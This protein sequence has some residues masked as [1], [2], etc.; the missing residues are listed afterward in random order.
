MKKIYD[1]FVVVCQVGTAEKCT[2]RVALDAEKN[3]N[4][5]VDVLTKEA[6]GQ[7]E[8]H[9]C[10]IEITTNENYMDLK[11]KLEEKEIK[12]DVVQHIVNILTAEFA[13][14]FPKKKK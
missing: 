5:N 3:M 12:N 1:R 2:E 10:L 14:E 9:P 6:I 11:S 4:Y 13:K 8:R 7:M